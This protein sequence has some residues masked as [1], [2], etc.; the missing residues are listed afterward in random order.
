MADNQAKIVLTAVDNTKVA[1][2]SAKRGLRDVEAAASAVKQAFTL[3][4]PF[5]GIYE[6]GRF[7]KATI[8]SADALNDL[9]NITGV[10]V[11]RL[12]AWKLAAEQSGTSIES[13]AKA[14]GKSSKYM[15][16]HG[17]NLRKMGLDG[18]TAEE[19]MIKLAGVISK[20]PADDPRRVAL[21]MEVMGK[22]AAELLPL[23]SNGAAGLK[24]MVRQGE[25]FSPVTKKMAEES[26]RFNDQLNLMKTRMS[27]GASVIMGEMLPSV[28][29]FLEKITGTRSPADLADDLFNEML[30]AGKKLN[31]LKADQ[32]NGPLGIF[33]T[34]DDIERQQRYIDSIAKRL[35]SVNAQVAA[36]QSSAA[37]EDTPINSAAISKVLAGSGAGSSGKSPREKFSDFQKDLLSDEEERI[38][39][40]AL[41]EHEQFE[42][43][44]K[45]QKEIDQQVA[46]S[47]YAAMVADGEFDRENQEKSHKLAVELL[48][49]ET[50]AQQ[51]ALEKQQA[52]YQKMIDSISQS[53]T[54]A[55]M[56]GFESGKGFLHNFIDTL[57][58]MFSTLVLRP[59][60]SGL[61]S[62]IGASISSG[63][64]GLF[65]M[66]GIA[67]ASDGSSSGSFGSIASVLKSGF[68]MVTG[69]FTA[70]VNTL[71]SSIG[72][73]FLLGNASTIGT[74]LGVASLALGAIGLFGGSLFGGGHVMRPKGYANTSI[75]ASGVSNIGSWTNGE[76]NVSQQAIDAGLKL[77]RFVDDMAKKLGGSI[78]DS[79][80]I[81]TKYMQKYGSISVKVGG[82]ASRD[83]MD[84]TFLAGDKNQVS[85]AFA[86]TF[87]DSVQKGL[88]GLDSYLEAYIGKLKDGSVG[89]SGRQAA[90]LQQTIDLKTLY[91]SLD[92]L[93]DV[94][95]RIKLAIESV[96]SKDMLEKMQALTSAT[97][98]FYNLFTPEAQ[99][100]ADNSAYVH[101][102]LAAL[103]VAF[104][105]TRAGF[106]ALVS[107]ID[108]SKQAGLDLYTTLVN[109]ASPMDQY[110][111]QIEAGADTFKQLA[112]ALSADQFQSLA[113]FNRAKA[114]R[115]YGYISPDLPMPAAGG[116]LMTRL[117][118]PA[119]SNA[120]ILAEL[121][122]LREV[123]AKQAETLAK[124]QSNT[125]TSADI[126]DNVTAG[127]GPMLTQVAV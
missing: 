80:V 98:N 67:N 103:N 76:G 9:S 101:K 85:N 116:A 10:A 69:T 2:D 74:A 53:L 104:P 63:V 21:A 39:K 28:N 79:F 78:E 72:S 109:L 51:K 125:K 36:Q 99:K 114:Y 70:G 43:S 57:K 5:A 108:T 123:N 120:A 46:K 122:N 83:G 107:G 65:G 20:L 92:L 105:D 24:E 64:A 89:N 110:F 52:E 93:P 59:V 14:L 19:V 88:V 90:F 42:K 12:S 18:K 50:E 48:Q 29:K 7:A 34:D 111:K 84:F 94:F 126:L 102:Q 11:E 106:M 6:I 45:L 100:V 44:A 61:V 16:E 112:D 82:G 75:S 96:A 68:D 4:I 58:N 97:Q 41:F 56:R 35:K 30:D 55:L 81:G 127:G 15:V 23:L 3:M 73:N 25:E 95:G 66:S 54:D 32:G 33:I 121:K 71:A 26:D 38:R 60:I 8:D 124:I 47:K 113:D 77:G 13:V 115:Q 27:A 1:L 119:T 31:Q 49:K 17:D 87:L 117:Q 22:S 62:P 37:K 118:D 91:D 86:R 40:A